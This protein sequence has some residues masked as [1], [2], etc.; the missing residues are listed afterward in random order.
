[1]GPRGLF[2]LDGAFS[3]AT[4]HLRVA[5]DL[6]ED[7]DGLFVNLVGM[8][9][10]PSVKAEIKG[11]GPLGEFAADLRLATSGQDRITGSMKLDPGQEEG[12]PGTNFRI[13]MGGDIA[14][15]V[16]P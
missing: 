13:E 2:S 6:D 1:D 3:N 4:R 15:I 16:P 9:G 14:T 7:A 10:L 12:A 8:D 5:L 11:E